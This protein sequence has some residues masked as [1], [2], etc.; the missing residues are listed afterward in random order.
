MARQTR[1]CSD[2]RTTVLIDRNAYG[3]GQHR[4]HAGL[5]GVAKHHGLSPFARR[6]GTH[7]GQGAEA[8]SPSEAWVCPA[9]GKP[10]NGAR[11]DP[12]CRHGQC[13]WERL[14]SGRCTPRIPSATK[15]RPMERLPKGRAH[16]LPRTPVRRTLASADLRDITVPQHGQW[17]TRPWEAYMTALPKDRV[18][19]LKLPAN[20]EASAAAAARSER[21]KGASAPGPLC[22]AGSQRQRRSKTTRSRAPRPTER[23]I[24]A[25]LGRNLAQRGRSYPRPPRCRNNASPAVARRRVSGSNPGSPPLTTRSTRLKLRRGKSDCQMVCATYST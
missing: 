6:S 1:S 22:L 2:N 14:G 25:P 11:F 8:H 4:F 5:R 13:A 24:G 9:V 17:S 3:L 16:R 21:D 19:R 15:A 10:F 7:K 18:A 20:L 12:R 23:Q